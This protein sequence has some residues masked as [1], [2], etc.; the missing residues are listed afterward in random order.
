[1]KVLAAS[2]HFLHGA[3][4]IRLGQKVGSSII[5]RNAGTLRVT[6]RSGV[7]L[8]HAGRTSAWQDTIVGT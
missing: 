5:V 6:T 7:F 2:P 4:R 3:E 1:M 8:E